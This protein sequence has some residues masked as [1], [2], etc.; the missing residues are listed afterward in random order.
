[1]YRLLRCM[2]QVIIRPFYR[3]R[4]VGREHLPS[5]A[6]VLCANHISYFDPVCLGLTL[7][8]PVRFMAKEEL[9]RCGRGIAGLF[10]RLCGVF[11][12]KRSSA[13]TASVNTAFRLLEKGKIV[14]IFPQ[15][16]IVREER[17]PVRTKG[18]AAL[19][20]TKAQVPLVPVSI[21][22]EGRIRPFVRI[23]VRVGCPLTAE[24]ASLRDARKLNQRLQASLQALWEEG[25]GD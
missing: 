9:F 22:A 14:G 19:L 1:M 2:A 16:G 11:P 6:F 15:G 8:R 17:S 25:H 23:T 18:G 4:I 13:D 5:G 12:V 3:I 10:L 24:G 7:R 20:V 21:Y